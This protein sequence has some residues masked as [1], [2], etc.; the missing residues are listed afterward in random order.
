[1]ATFPARRG[2]H[3]VGASRRSRRRG[4]VCR[5][6]SHGVSRGALVLTGVLALGGGVA[7]AA[8]VDGHSSVLRNVPVVSALASDAS[9]WVG[10]AATSLRGGSDPGSRSLSETVVRPA[11]PTVEPTPTPTPTP[12]PPEIAAVAATPVLID[13]TVVGADG[14]T[15][16]DHSAGL[17]SA[18]VP[19]AASGD[20]IIVSGSASA[21][22]PDR[23]VRTI[24]VE[25]ESGL[26]IDADVFAA[27]VMT[28]LND[29]RGWGGDG[30]LSFARTDGDADYRVV[31]ASPDLVDEMCAPLATRGQVSCGRAGHAV[32]NFR[33]WSQATSEFTDKTQYRQYV[34]NHEVGHLLGH[35]HEYCGGSGQI[36]PLMQQQSYGVAPCI[37][38]GWAFP[39]G[40]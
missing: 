14:L 18:E 37:P 33:R 16:A 11:V 23:D 27:A 15:F 6:A 3:A 8:V 40:A 20:L 17:L 31:L 28:T 19:T 2:L 32:I 9:A 39:D 10:G 12:V 24:R 21:P 35:G 13:A 4:G 5:V 38:N 36:A 1:M 34:I 30:S 25:V 7:S 26:P 22:H 29:P